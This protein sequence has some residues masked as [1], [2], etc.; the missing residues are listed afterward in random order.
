MARQVLNPLSLVA[1]D[2]LGDKPFDYTAKLN[3]MTQELYDFNKDSNVIPITEESDFPTQDASKITLE[4]GFIYDIKKPF[5]TTKFFDCQGGSMKGG[6]SDVPFITYTGSGF[7]FDINQNLFGL[8]LLHV[9]CPS[10]VFM[11]IVGD[12]TLSLATFA[13]VNS[14]ILSSCIGVARAEAGGI[15]SYTSH[16]LN[17]IINGSAFEFIGNSALQSLNRVSISGLTATGIAIDFGT[18][19]ITEG[20][21]DDVIVGGNAAATAVSGLTNSG[22]TPVGGNISFDGCNFGALTTPLVGV[23]E[24]DIRNQFGERNSSN[25]RASQNAGDLFLDGGSETI[26]VASSGDWNEIGTPAGAATWQGDIADRFT[27]NAAGFITYIGERT[28]DIR[29][30]ARAT[31]EKVGGGADEIECRLAKNWTGATTDAGF[32]KSRAGTQNATPTSVP[33]GALT[34]AETNDNFRVIFSN[35]D[36]SSDI[37]ASVTSLEIRG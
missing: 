7:M 36:G 14:L 6:F 23:K 19:V 11:R 18:A 27:I 17:G 37:I 3:A 29:L 8:D 32:S 4:S 20:E 33:M 21:F 1:D 28:I 22:N 2:G 30:T 31:V 24:N 16:N 15:L 5:T 35:N 26:A 10:A 12:G 13:S 9:A 34:T 25:I